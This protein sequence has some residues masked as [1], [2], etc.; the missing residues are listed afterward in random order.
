MAAT[1]AA[2]IS[3]MIVD[4]YIFESPLGVSHEYRCA[5][6]PQDPNVKSVWG[7]GHAYEEKRTKIDLK[8]YLS[9]LL[10]LNVNDRS[11]FDRRLQKLGRIRPDLWK[12]ARYCISS[13]TRGVI[14]GRLP[15]I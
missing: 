9:Q 5:T 8:G 15:L 1:T 2:A 6:L 11:D 13:V 14:G 3:R 4:V 12:K 10:L 7:S